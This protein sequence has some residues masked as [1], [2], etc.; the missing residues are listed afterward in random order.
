M[1]LSVAGAS[2]ER[3]RAAPQ[4]MEGSIAG[5]LVSTRRHVAV[6]MATLILLS[7]VGVVLASGVARAST[8]FATGEVFASVGNASVETFNPSSG[9]SQGTLVDSTGDQFTVGSAFDANGNY[10]VADDFTGSVSEYSPTGQPMPTF[11]TGLNAPASLVFDNSGN[12]Y[13][14]QQG[15]PYIAEFNSSG[16]RLPDIGLLQTDETGADWIDL[17]SDQCTF[18]YTT[19]SNNIFAYNK[20]TNTQLPNFNQ[21]PLSGDN[22][23][24][25][26]ILQNGDVLVADTE[27]VVMLDPNGNVIQ[28]YPCSSMPFC[29]NG[30]FALAIDPTGTSFWAGDAFSGNI[31][32]VNIATGQVMQTIS[33]N[34]P[35]LLGLSVDGEQEAAAAPTVVAA[36]PATLT[37]QPI[38][39]DFSSPTPVSAVLTD[40]TTG[41]PIPDEPVTFTL[42]GTET[43]S[44]T[45]D[46]TGTATCVITPG[47]PSQSYTLTASF[48]GDATT[49]TPIGSDSAGSTFTVTPD[50]SSLV[51]TGPTTAVNG[52]PTTLSGDV[53]TDTPTSGTPLP[54]KVV[55]FTLG[56]GSTAQTC[57]DMTQLDGS[58]SCTIPSV[59]QPVSQAPVTATFGGD[60]FNSQTSTTTSLLVTEPTTLTVHSSTGDYADATTV[61]GVLT[62]I[63]PTTNAITP[64]VGEPVKLTL[65]NNETCTATTDA[66]GTASCS[67][68]PSEP[69]ATYPL[70]GS[71]AG[72][73]TVDP[74]LGL[75][76][77]S[78][79]GASTFVVTQEETALTYT[80][81][82]IAH[83]GQPLAVSGVLTTDDPAAGT[84]IAN[85]TVTF[86]LGTGS[87]AQACTATTT[88]AGLAACS[89][90]SVNQS[91]GPIPVTDT[92]AGD[93][94]Y[95]TASASSTVNVPENT[96]LTVNPTTG[97]YNA[98]TPVS[99]T[100]VNTYMGL[101]SPVT[102][103]PV[104]LTVNGTQ[105]CTA[106]TNASGVAT[107]SIT[108]NEP[109]GPYSLTGTFSGD[110]NSMPPL[111]GSTATSTFTV[112]PA[113]T[114]FTATGPTSVTNGQPATLTGVLTTT[115]PTL[116][117]DV[118]GAPVTLTLGSGTS[119][120]SCTGTTNGSGAAS[121]TIASVTQTS[122][123][124]AVVSG[125]FGGN[126]DYQPS[127]NVPKTVQVYTPTQLT[128]TAVTAPYGGSDTVTGVLKNWAGVPLSGEPVTLTL[129]STQSCTG[130]TG[131]GGVV[132][133]TIIPNE[134]SGSYTLSGSF[135]GD[136]SKGPQYLPSGG[137]NTFVVTKAATTVVSTGPSIEVN[138]M[139]ITLSA[140]LT[141]A[142]GTGPGG[143]PV[144]LTLGSGSSA[145]SCTGTANAS[146]NVSC[147]IP[148]PNQTSGSVALTVSYGGNT[149]YLP[150]GA[151]TTVTTASL[152]TSGDFVVGDVSAG[153]PTKGT[154]VNF[155]GSQLWKKNAFS[156]VDN[157]PA[158][159]KG[160]I[161]NAPALSCKTSTG[162]VPTWTSNPGNSS[163]PPSTIPVNMVVVVGSYINQSG[164][165]ESGNIVHLVV[166]Q[167]AAGYG[168]NPGHDGYGQI[169]ATIC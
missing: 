38:S 41:A 145:Q 58:A 132:T 124:T 100:L 89:I 90:A 47:E 66:T 137:S 74:T 127:T 126:N 91:P 25:L 119:Q 75:E 24:E 98:S 35:F 106:T 146:G 81:A 6:L 92:F 57:T 103:E 71:F 80:G 87:S 139:P 18:Y 153:A 62:D 86:T 128:V 70:T 123:S 19:E 134:P 15:T 61:S 3:R 17:S 96:Q 161:D 29:T 120:Q 159:M 135:G 8:T 40:S 12:L 45:T 16:Q 1:R 36:A 34:S 77:T 140:N 163:G 7:T 32:Q 102:G 162:G 43:C 55:T 107:C 133:C 54:A 59:D 94:Y 53:T 110:S 113:P 136:T 4:T 101:N 152:P 39:G 68:T 157:A 26:R 105:S 151:S 114:T 56:S 83:D 78:S 148:N 165:T 164:S 147:T 13:V 168:P 88:A 138:G 93:A 144:V 60:V 76:L 111:N 33:T 63:N 79:T 95:Q 129:N 51:S 131:S 122:G 31:W 64:V 44:G 72:D 42:N 9:T 125:S 85:R 118:S 167:V 82:T 21:A 99:A 109:A 2:R 14:G 142:G 69:A 155:W 160:Y 73:A 97:I 11:A 169:L 130:T 154:V 115:E 50:H 158:S 22:A 5:G 116:G 20:C 30:L 48:S 49:T 166:V 143:L 156:G 108:P 149:Y 37:V 28:N 46:D 65:D 67:I 150:S 10:Y 141:T 84:G 27:S 104:T 121:C 52:Q 112:T 23:F 117:T